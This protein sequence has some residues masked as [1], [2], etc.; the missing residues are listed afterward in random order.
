MTE[1][2]YAGHRQVPVHKRRKE[3]ASENIDNPGFAAEANEIISGNKCFK[4]IEGGSLATLA[5]A[6]AENQFVCRVW[7]GERIPPL[8]TDQKQQCACA[9]GRENVGRPNGGRVVFMSPAET[10]LHVYACR[11]RGIFNI[12]PF[13][14]ATIDPPP[15]CMS[16][17]A[18]NS[19][20]YKHAFS[21]NGLGKRR[22]G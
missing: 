9:L 15:T 2:N 22:R 11:Y 14:S 6:S 17:Y 21:D 12:L 10:A 5:T 13:D 4:R 8:Q 1:I 18:N 3:A 20:G 19:S 16:S 7:G